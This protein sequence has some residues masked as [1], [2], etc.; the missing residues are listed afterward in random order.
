MN[1]WSQQT[2][3]L[4]TRLN[5]LDR[6]QTIY[7]HEEG[8]RN[9]TE[10]TIASIR[11]AFADGDANRLLDELLSL[12]KFPYKDSYVAF[13]RKDR[14][15]IDR[16]AET[17]KRIFDNLS[18]MGIE[19]IIAGVSQAKEANMRRGPQFSSWLRAQYPIVNEDE[20][21]STNDSIL[22]LEGGEEVGLKFCN[23]TLKLGI[24]KRPDLVAKAGSRY[25]V[26]EAKF[27]S[28]LGGN[29]GRAFDD[30]MKLATNGAGR[31]YKIFI[32]DGVIWLETGS[33]HYQDI[34]N[35]NAAV[36]S[37]ILLPQYLESV[38]QEV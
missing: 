10:K 23:N 35:S 32:L 8:E 24:T 15:A 36:L 38:R 12:E 11:E 22:L 13:L 21:R 25:I 27:L 19:G 20:F 26:G 14:T 2:Q 17:V 18:R 3:Q 6:L 1:P 34:D 29:Q 31:A 28:S 16:N 5:Y 9:I 4:V 33:S 30:G 37:A 7:A